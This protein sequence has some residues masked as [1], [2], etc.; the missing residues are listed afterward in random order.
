MRRPGK[1][2]LNGTTVDWLPRNTANVDHFNG[3]RNFDKRT[4]RIGFNQRME[5]Y[6]AITAQHHQASQVNAWFHTFLTLTF[7]DTKVPEKPNECI[8]R[9]FKEMKRW[10]F[11]NYV[12]TREIG[13]VGGLVHYHYTTVGPSR[14]VGDINDLWCHIRKDY[15][16]NAV[17]TE[18]DPRTGK[19]R[20][21][22]NS[23]VAA[24][25]Y[26]A[27][28]MTK[29]YTKRG[30]LPE[31]PAGVT[32][33]PGKVWAR[34]HDLAFEPVPWDSP[35]DLA[36]DDYYGA[37]GKVHD[38]DH[39][40]VGRVRAELAYQVYQEARASWQQS[41]QAFSESEQLVSERREKASQRAALARSQGKL[42][43]K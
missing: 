14:P 12:W 13:P 3:E 10:G 20:M 23:I 8:T 40:R 34:S 27:K 35:C 4:Y 11:Q 38:G 29:E 26:V 18:K 37:K 6:D 31:I 24:R 21:V 7:R 1:I 42:F 15:S 28:Y 9:F 32:Q 33:V 5:I 22:I 16:S 2:Y 17:R 36:Y 25:A 19:Y 43:D 41:I 30:T 39:A